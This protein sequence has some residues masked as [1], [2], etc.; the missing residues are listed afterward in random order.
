MIFLSYKPKT[1]KDQANYL[2]I[3]KVIGHRK[4]SCE[5]KSDNNTENG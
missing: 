1:S 4:L 3:R 2:S 5:V